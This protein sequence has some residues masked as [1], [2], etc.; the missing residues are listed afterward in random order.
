MQHEREPLGRRQRVQDHQQRQ[1]D[2]VGQQRLLLGVEHVGLADDR[3][4]Q[5]HPQ[6]FFPPGGARAQHVQAHRATTV[7]SQPPRL[8]APPGSRTF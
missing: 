5:V 1:P 3:V 6:R 2:R 7:V 8:S 4:G